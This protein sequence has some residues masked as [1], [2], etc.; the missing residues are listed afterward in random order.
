MKTQQT[1]AIVLNT[2]DYGESDRLVTFYTRTAGKI[3]GLAKGARRSRKR[4]VHVFE[5]CS[6]VELC[7]RERKTLVW[8]ES[9]KLLEPY[10]LLRSNLDRWGHAALLS[11]VV[12]E[13]SP[14]ADSQE[15]LFVLLKETLE[16]LSRDRDPQ[17]VMVLFLLRFLDASGYLP[18][19]QE[20]GVCRRPLQD[21]TL[22]G[23]A[24]NRGVLMCPG[25]PSEDG[26]SLTLDLGTLLLVQQARR[27][28]LDR[29]WRLRLQ[30][31]KRGPLF[32]GLV[33]W[34]SRHINHPLK[35]L[36][37]LEQIQSA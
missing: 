37:L 32:N 36:K 31:G 16:Q 4:F 17:N 21:S 12:Q 5:L 30:Q 27:L 8:I 23:W 26:G 9:C 2:R 7:Y 34:I 19:L 20:C 1:E 11:E 3:R 10:L 35:S 29:V 14:E 13:M 28:P 22:W 18:G 33:E 6:L 25:H 15:E 24:I